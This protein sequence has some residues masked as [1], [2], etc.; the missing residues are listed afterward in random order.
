MLRKI[1]FIGTTLW[2][3]AIS[4]W[5]QGLLVTGVVKDQE[6]RKAL[7]NVNITVEGSNIGTVTNADGGFSLSVSKEQL[8]HPKEKVLLT[9][10]TVRK[11]LWQ[12]L[13]TRLSVR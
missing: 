10:A 7:A 4:A 9:K 12:V 11:G 6:T 5:A 3:L 2:L 13:H 8:L 1:F